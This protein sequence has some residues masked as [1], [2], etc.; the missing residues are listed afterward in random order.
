MIRYDFYILKLRY[1]YYKSPPGEELVT[2]SLLMRSGT[3]F[4][5]ADLCHFVSSVVIF[6]PEC[7]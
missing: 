1:E 3:L 5:A 7:L 6:S 4:S 2:G